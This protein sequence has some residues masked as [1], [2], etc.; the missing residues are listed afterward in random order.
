MTYRMPQGK[1]VISSHARKRAHARGQGRLGPVLD[2]VARAWREDL[3]GRVA[4]VCDPY[5]IPIVQFR[6]GACVVVTVLG[7]DYGINRH[8]QVV[9]LSPHGG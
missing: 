7:R 2:L 8:T 3:R 5:P 9:Q 6:P 1:V 4:I